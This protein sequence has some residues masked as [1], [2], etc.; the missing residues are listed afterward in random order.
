MPIGPY[1]TDFCCLAAKLIVE[2]DG[3]QHAEAIDRDEERRRF[4]ENQGF[5]VLRFTNDDVRG[6]L[7]WVMQEI[8]RTLDL[9][10]ANNA[11]Q[12]LQKR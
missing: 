5:I 1:T 4:I 8:G 6:R 11:R 9:A 3:V 12:A 2:V 7:N 10:C